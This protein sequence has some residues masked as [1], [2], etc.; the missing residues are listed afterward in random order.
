MDALMTYLQ[1][2]PI[3]LM[4]ILIAVLALYVSY[5]SKH[6]A[7]KAFSLSLFDKRYKL[8]HEFKILVNKL[9]LHS[10]EKFLPEYLHQIKLLLWEAQYVFDKDV[11]DLLDDIKQHISGCIMYYSVADTSGQQPEE[12]ALVHKL[13][14]EHYDPMQLLPGMLLSGDESSN[15]NFYFHKYLSDKNLRK[16]LVTTPFFQRG[17]KKISEFF[18][19]N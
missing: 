1:Q 18:K 11:C 9:L 3:E 5:L 16:P 10:D 14:V 15:L 8:Y 4:A 19:C 17:R 13:K 2:H 7:E 12:I 6:Y